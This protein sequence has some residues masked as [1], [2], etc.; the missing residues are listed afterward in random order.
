MLCCEPD[1]FSWKTCSKTRKY[2]ASSFAGKYFESLK[3]ILSG[4]LNFVNEI[5]RLINF[6]GNLKEFFAR[7]VF[8]VALIAI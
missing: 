7:D 8:L 5:L 6:L 1:P 4:F 2:S 3:H